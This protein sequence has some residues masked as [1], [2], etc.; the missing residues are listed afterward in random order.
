MGLVIYS[1]T[2]SGSGPIKIIGK[3]YTGSEGVNTGLIIL[4]ASFLLTL[5]IC[6]RWDKWRFPLLIVITSF[7]AFF[8]RIEFGKRIVHHHV[9]AKF[10][11]Q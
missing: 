1:G 8:N 7:L 5:E 3:I 6:L 2:H 4:K 10:H 11:L 9:L